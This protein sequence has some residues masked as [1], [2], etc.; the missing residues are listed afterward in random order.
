[1]FRPRRKASDFSAEIEAHI[2]LEAERWREQGLAED[3]SR[4]AR[5]EPLAT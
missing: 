1:M 2:Q 4:A 5:A 3:E